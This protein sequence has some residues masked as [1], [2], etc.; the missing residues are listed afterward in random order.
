MEGQD[1]MDV[2]E[3]TGGEDWCGRRGCRTKTGQSP[4]VVIDQY[5]GIVEPLKV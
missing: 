5:L 3:D 4:G 2:E 1:D